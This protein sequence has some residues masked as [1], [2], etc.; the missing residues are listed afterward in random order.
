MH[1]KPVV[2]LDPDGHYDPLWA[3]LADLE[4]R[5]FVRPE[6]LDTLLLARTVDDA[7]AAVETGRLPQP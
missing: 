7:L 5:G 2:V 4:K 1:A 3:W 6:A